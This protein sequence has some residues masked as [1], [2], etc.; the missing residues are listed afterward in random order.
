MNLET[1]Q[2][3]R[4]RRTSL[5]KWQLLYSSFFIVNYVFYRR[6][7]HDTRS[8]NWAHT[9]LPDDSGI[10]GYSITVAARVAGSI[11]PIKYLYL[12]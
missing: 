10:V 8:K 11:G 2:E 12:F 4:W 7:K 5:H 6:P 3:V 1:F 9:C